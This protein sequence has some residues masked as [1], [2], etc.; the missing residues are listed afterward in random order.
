MPIQAIS[1]IRAS[2]AAVSYIR[3]YTTVQGHSGMGLEA[4]REAIARFAKDQNYTIAD[5]H[6]EVESGKGA[7]LLNVGPSW[8]AIMMGRPQDAGRISA[9]FGYRFS[10]GPGR[11]RQGARRAHRF[12]N[13]TSKYS[14]ET[15]EAL[16]P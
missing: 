14:T 16:C 11:A 12:S 5:E 15:P 7:G 6:V 13:T 9:E 3:I 8:R 4:Q 10:A 1:G 2:E